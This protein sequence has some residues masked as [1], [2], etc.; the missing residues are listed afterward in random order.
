MQM[1]GK[2]IFFEKGRD[3]NYF[4]LQQNPEDQN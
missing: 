2:N 1:P 4:L 3:N